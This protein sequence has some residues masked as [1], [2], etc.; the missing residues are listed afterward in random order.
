MGG[1]TL[2][3]RILGMVRDIVCA[4]RFGTNW[5]W[6]GFLYAFM[7][8]NFFRRLVAEGALSSSFIPIYSE[9]LEKK[10]KE[11]AIRFAHV[12]FTFLMVFFAIFL[13]IVEI[14]LSAALPLVKDY[15]ILHLA[16]DLMRV[17]FPY[18]WLM[19]LFALGMGILNSH[20]HFWVPSLGPIILNVFW[21]IGVL[22]LIPFAGDNLLAQ[23][24]ALAYVLVAAGLTQVLFEMPE[25]Y[26]LGFRFKWVWD[27]AL[28]EFLKAKKLILP[29]I[30]GF[31]VVPI[32]VLVDMSLG[33]FIGE[34]ANSSLWYGNRLMQF[35]L[36]IFA[37][38]I[39][40]A[41]LPTLSAFGASGREH[42]FNRTVLFS[43]K[44]VFLIILPCSLG[45]I[46]LSEP[47][48]RLLF[49]RG[50][51]DAESTAR[52]ASVLIC[53]SVGLIGFSGQKIIATGF[54]SMQ[55]TKT[56]A[57]IAVIALLLNIILNLLLMKPLREAGLA[58]A[59]SISGMIHFCSLIFFL[60]VK[61]QNLELRDLLVPGF[62]I[63]L[64][65]CA[66]G[67]ICMFSYHQSVSYFGSEQLIGRL[68]QV[69]LPIAASIIAYPMFC[70]LF[71]LKSLGQT[72][73]WLKDH[74]G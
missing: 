24:H 13:A 2:I 48:I 44:N 11:A 53:Y 35:P 63:F 67:L 12:S 47:I 58:L 25:L 26:K 33:L 62:K 21:I 46:L 70:I 73:T 3:S 22:W 72:L 55:D 29:A 14:S 38:A 40:T 20:K 27:F 34:G 31:A 49:Q 52:T 43:L 42:E 64:A 16:L 50:A 15:Q 59:T 6:D 4:G 54:Y 1:L 17:F 19:A 5:Q 10:G 39:G 41:L 45:L 37:I 23:V 66:M 56:P 9:A 8:P 74:F 57:K 36:A 30:L 7:V 60:K 69:V 51:F 61:R 28:E 32:N 68:L 65:T 18:L 71:G